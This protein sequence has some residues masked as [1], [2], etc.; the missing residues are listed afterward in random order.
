M[1]LNLKSGPGPC[2]WQSRLKAVCVG[3]AGALLCWAT[4]A[5]AF[6][7]TVVV[8]TGT[9]YQ[10]MTGWEVTARNWEYNKVEDRF[11][12]AWEAYSGSIFSALVDEGGI[13]RIRL[14][15]K[16]G[17]ENPH[18][19]WRDF[20]SGRIGYREYKAKF[21]EKINDNADPES[22]NP[23][24]FQFGALDYAVE[25][26]LLP[27][28]E[29]L[30]Q[31]GE[32]LV[33]NLCYQDF[34]HSDSTSQISHALDSA[35]YAE[36][37]LAAFRHLDD[38]Y[39][40][41]PDYF[42]II[43]EP[44][45]TRGWGGVEIGRALVAVKAKLSAA[46]YSPRFI[47]PA[48]SRLVA[49]H[50]FFD[51]MMSVPGADGA[52][53]VYAYHRY[54]SEW[55]PLW[56][57]H[58]ILRGI[59]ARAREIGVA[60]AMTEYLNGDIE[61]LFDDLTLANVSAWQIWGIA[62]PATVRG[63]QDGVMLLVNGDAAGSESEPAVWLTKKAAPAA[64]IFRAVRA[65]AVRVA[66]EASDSVLRV[67]A[68]AGPQGGFSLHLYPATAERGDVTLRG[69]PPGHYVVESVGPEGERRVEG[70]VRVDASGSTR[71]SLAGRRVFS[72]LGPPVVAGGDNQ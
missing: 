64:A 7:A 32:A 70:S 49:A 3:L 61:D 68:F 69:L 27:M 62:E 40:L 10:I 71:V 65:G 66:G 18:D 2:G 36:L 20:A 12:P 51:R 44:D 46:G 53:D 34:R 60:T 19:Y 22:A 21:Y 67:V 23:E 48:T 45:K 47:A 17:F 38:K 8:D 25:T 58:Y 42:E 35:E 9:R 14:A 43:L 33:V 5:H 1:V 28:Q 63:D 59:A 30:R 11:D 37:V 50:Y 4:A 56:G 26:M 16:S 55:L 24:G 57:E 72:L 52:L 41:V 13:N 15:L 54:A 39:G 31:R 29:N 6:D